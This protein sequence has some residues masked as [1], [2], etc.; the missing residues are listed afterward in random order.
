MLF[1]VRTLLLPS[2]RVFLAF[3]HGFW[4]SFVLIHPLNLK[5]LGGEEVKNY[6]RIK[7]LLF[8]IASVIV[9]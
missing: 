9:C 6:P 3:L 7:R 8:N 2:P 4:I 1:L 5:F